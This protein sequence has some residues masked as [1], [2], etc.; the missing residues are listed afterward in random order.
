MIEREWEQEE[1]VTT[2]SVP[3][4][5]FRSNTF[6]FVNIDT[7]NSKH[8]FEKRFYETSQHFNSFN[9]FRQCL[10]Q[11]FYWLSEWAKI[12]WGFSKYFFKLKTSAVYLDKQKSCNPKNN[13]TQ[14]WNPWFRIKHEI[15]F[16]AF[17][18]WLYCIK[19]WVTFSYYLVL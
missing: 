13:M 16:I 10:F 17:K 1:K 6:L 11:F 15:N 7:W 14:F 4:A 3:R 2:N 18:L 12:L 19:Q 9:L 8:L 5:C